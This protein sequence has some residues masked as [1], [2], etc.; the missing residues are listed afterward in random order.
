MKIALSVIAERLGLTV[1][2]PD[3]VISGVNTLEKAGPSDLTFLANPRYVPMLPKTRAGAV[4]LSQE[5]ASQVK[6]GLISANPYYDFVR[7]VTM[8][9]KPQGSM[10]GISP[11][12][13]IHEQASL[14]QNCTVYPFVF[15]GPAV[16]IGKNTTIFPN[17]YIGENCAIGD[18]CLLYPG[19]KLMSGTTVGHRT[20]L[21]PGVVLGSDG[22]G[23]AMTGQTREKFPQIG[24][25]SIGDDVEIGANTTVDRAALDETS[26]GGGTKMDNQIQ[27][28]H[29][30]RIGENCVIVAQVG[31]AGSTTVGDGVIIA[32][33]VGVAGHLKIGNNVTIGPCTSLNRDLPDNSVVGGTPAMDRG[34]FLRSS[35]IVPKLPDM[36]KRIRNLEKE[37]DHLKNSLSSK[38]DDHV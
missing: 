15:I 33:Q 24:R 5:L 22:F 30:V 38:G 10:S 19:V 29:N 35:A 7:I 37:L 31:I 2:G 11:L 12:A 3:V 9:A 23:F 26:I 17:C 36:A 1:N 4:I 32:G 8:F 13:Y 27:I 6:T 16:R 14:G 20:V 21:H 18:D 28:G 25:V 34:T